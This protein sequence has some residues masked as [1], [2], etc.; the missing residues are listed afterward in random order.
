MTDPY[1]RYAAIYDR[2]GQARFG[3]TLA[4]TALAHL[5]ERSVRLE[6]AIDLATGT[7]AAAIEM[8]TRG[9]HVTGYDRS[10]EMLREARRKSAELGL[11][12]EWRIGAMERFE[13]NDPVNLVTCFYDSM[14]YLLE[15]ELLAS[16][17][18]AVA[19]SLKPGGWFVFDVNTIGRF[20]TDWN[21]AT[22]VAYEDDDLLCLFRSTYDQATHLSPLLLT[23]FERDRTNRLVWRRWDEEHVE[24]GY[25][26]AQLSGLLH[27]AGF[28][29]DGVEAFNEVAM[30][31]QGPANDHSERALFFAQLCLP[32]AKIPA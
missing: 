25:P 19:R 5:T 20:E 11:D 24:R 26:L 28:S 27:A 10:R 8:A 6:S 2:T 29:V 12:I 17:F 14:N 23:V 32:T 1:Q 16:C 30:D 13:A 21:R 7:G 22:Q 31:L 15:P 18:A 9:V 3:A 4:R